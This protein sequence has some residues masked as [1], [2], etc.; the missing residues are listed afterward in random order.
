NGNLTS[1]SDIGTLSYNDPLHP[2]AVTGAGSDSFSY[3]PVGNQT[4]RPGAMVAY[5]PFDLPKTITKSTG[6][7]T[8]AYDGDEQR[9]RKTTA[10]EETIYFGDLYEHVG[11]PSSPGAP[12]VDRF[13]VHS[14]ER[15][16]AVVTRGGPK[17]GTLYLHVDHLGS[18][19]TLTDE[20]GAAKEK[21]SYDP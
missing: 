20:S 8:F 1:K 16:V 14:P 9:I 18:I 17:P 12:G 6:T 13:Y 21:R 5:T 4:A 10:A 2:H 3:D 7:V 15:V 19:E 11:D